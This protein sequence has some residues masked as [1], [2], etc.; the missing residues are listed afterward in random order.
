MII[1][2]LF[3]I[4]NGFFLQSLELRFSSKGTLAYHHSLT[5]IKIQSPLNDNFA[6]TI[7][8][9]TIAG[10]KLQIVNI[11]IPPQ[12]LSSPN[13]VATLSSISGNENFIV[14]DINTHSDL[15]SLGANDNRGDLFCKQ[16]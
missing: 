8:K 5:Y 9:T 10:L 3:T 4:L 15:W 13:Y 12:S 16:T 1:S 14:G 2:T 6:E 7:I 11:Y